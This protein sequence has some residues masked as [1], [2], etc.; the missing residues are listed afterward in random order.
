MK[1]T[2]HANSVPW[3]REYLPRFTA[4]LAAHGHRVIH[5]TDDEAD[6]DAVNIIFAN[7]SWKLTHVQC[8]NK[9]IPLLTV[10][11]CFFGSRFDM[12][13]I[14]WDGFNACGDFCLPDIAPADRWEKHGV[15]LQSWQDREG[16]VLVC[17]E[18]RATPHWDIR[19]KEDLAGESVRFRPHPFKAGE[20]IHGWLRPPGAVQDGIAESLA[21]ARVCVTMDSIAG[22][23]SVIAGVPTICYGPQAMAAPVSFQN[24]RQYMIA[25]KHIVESLDQEGM[26]DREPWARRLAYCQWDHDEITR[27]EFWEH[28]K[29]RMEKEND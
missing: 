24:W 8:E 28:L 6:P 17:G 25:K 27:G 9:N 20:S 23:D 15:E 12:V 10:G 22:C 26:P 5:T 16:Y 2:I 21:G 13:S 11:R 14:G 4:G 18:Y 19:L 1:F 29:V 3:Q 7:N